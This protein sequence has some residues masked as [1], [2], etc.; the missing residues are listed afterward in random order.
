MATATDR[1]TL[2]RANYT[3]AMLVE[4][5]LMSASFAVG[6]EIDVRRTYWR[7]ADDILSAMHRGDDAVLE[8]IRLATTKNATEGKGS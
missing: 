6:L 1:P 5:E 7:H 3:L 2:T 8:A 4:R